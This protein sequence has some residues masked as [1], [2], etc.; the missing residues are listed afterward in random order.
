MCQVISLLGLYRSTT[1]SLPSSMMLETMMVCIFVEIGWH[2]GRHCHF[3]W[4]LWTCDSSSGMAQRRDLRQRDWHRREVRCLRSTMQL[5]TEKSSNYSNYA[6]MRFAPES[7]HDANAGLDLA[8]TLMEKIKAEFPWISYGDLWTL[9]GVCAVQVII[10]GGDD[11]YFKANITRL[12]RKW[13]A[14]KSPGGPVELMVRLRMRLRMAVSQML[15][16]VPTT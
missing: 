1:R 11:H 12:C 2:R 4:F 5:L 8:R 10:Q 7:L 13:L 16:R 15:L 6:T 14:R 3:R 9:G